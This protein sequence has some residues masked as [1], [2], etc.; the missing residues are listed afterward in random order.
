MTEDYSLDQH[1]LDETGL[2][3]KNGD[4]GFIAGTHSPYQG[5]GFISATNRPG[6]M[7][8]KKGN[9]ELAG[10]TPRILIEINEGSYED[11]IKKVIDF[12]KQ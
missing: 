12:L 9:I 6:F 5:S 1:I 2:S 10:E 8:W 7:V 11:A 4:Y 3:L